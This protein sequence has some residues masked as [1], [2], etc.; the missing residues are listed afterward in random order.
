MLARISLAAVLS[1]FLIT[2]VNALTPT[3]AL[4]NRLHEIHHSPQKR[5]TSGGDAV[6]LSD[7]PSQC[8]AGCAPAVTA[9][10]TC[11][12]AACICNPTVAKSLQQCVNCSVNAVPDPSVV[13]SGQQV[14]DTYDNLCAGSGL[15]SLSLT[16]GSPNPT[17]SFRPVGGGGGSGGGPTTGFTQT[18][19]EGPTAT[20]AGFPSTTAGGGGG[21]NPLGGGNNAGISM[22]AGYYYGVPA[23]LGVLAALLVGAPA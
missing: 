23:G 8:Q 13:Q 20:I 2:T 12:S 11:T 15:T 19:F 9:I 1:L 22:H 10:N 14:L 4:L 21:G 5:Q 16:V 18:T 6:P 3:E 17:S 7:F